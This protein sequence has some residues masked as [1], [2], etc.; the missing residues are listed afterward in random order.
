MFDRFAILVGQFRSAWRYRW[1]A[2][3]AMWL[4]AILGWAIVFMIPNQYQSSARVFVETNTV[5]RPLLEGIAVNANTGSQVDLV[6]RALLS[7]KQ[8]ERVIDET[9]LQLRV[10]DAR[11]RED[12]LRELA[13]DIDISADASS[14]AAREAN[15]FTIS[16]RDRD[17]EL[18][19]TVVK[20]LLDTFLSQSMGANRSDADAAQEFLRNQIADYERRLTES[21][22]RLAEFKKENVGA[23]PDERG[24]Y[25]QR[26][27]SESVALDQLR[28]N[29]SVAQQRRAGLRTKLLGGTSSGGSGILE[30]SVDQRIRD[31]SARLEELLLRFTEQH[32]DVLALRQTIGRLEAQRRQE[33]VSRSSDTGAV[34][35]P[36]VSTNLVTQNL[37][38]ALNEAEA[39]LAALQAQARDS[40]QRVDALRRQINTLPGVEA[41]LLRLNRDYSVTRSEYER[42]LQRLESA[43]LSNAANR[44]DEVRFKTI[45]PP[46]RAVL[47]VS[48]KRPLLLLG[49]VAVALAGGIGLA[50]LLSQLRPIFVQSSQLENYKGLPV[51][52]VLSVAF[53]GT[54][55]ERRGRMAVA[56]A[57]CVLLAGSAGLIVFHSNVESVSSS[58]LSMV[59]V[60]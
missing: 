51:Y 20:G 43:K 48:P 56:A 18:A 57:L 55:S 34:G 10:K 53:P 6:R 16:Y 31:E 40:E 60:Q 59:N 12:M 23:M 21:E 50:W 11:E 29:L 5:L 32:P 39:Q 36:Q 58:L 13:L 25:F 30:T 24:G 2:V 54:A 45:D 49:V 4:L 19:F 15:I 8:L 14:P 28:A 17:K 38:I 1:Q 35:R 22:T 46:V 44:M 37:Q 9:D 47:P 27:Q 52:G 26:L 7:R 3:A 33:I 41:E 42:L